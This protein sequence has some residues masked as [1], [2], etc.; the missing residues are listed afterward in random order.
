MTYNT[1]QIFLFHKK[2]S[3]KTIDAQFNWILNLL[4][5]RFHKAKILILGS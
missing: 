1:I 2:K 5:K 3:I 4:I